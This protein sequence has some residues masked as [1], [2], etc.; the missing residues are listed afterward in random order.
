MNRHTWQDYPG[1]ALSQSSRPGSGH[2][3]A[4]HLGVTFH[5]LLNNHKAW[6]GKNRGTKECE[7]RVGTSNKQGART[8]WYGHVAQVYKLP[9]EAIRKKL[10]LFDTFPCCT[11]SLQLR[12][13][14]VFTE[15]EAPLQMAFLS[16]AQ[17][18]FEAHIASATHLVILET[19]EPAAPSMP[20]HFLRSRSRLR[21][22][23]RLRS[24]NRPHA[25]QLL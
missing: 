7:Q 13:H 18:C 22:R 23:S 1:S 10:A 21:E 4:G 19:L 15:N 9:F 24:W 17:L 8:K 16:G 25:R 2:A 20:P 11:C 5:S 3:R 12:A 6:V 14:R